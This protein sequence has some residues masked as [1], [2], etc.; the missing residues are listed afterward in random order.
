M[1]ARGPKV[2]GHGS[3]RLD[4][5]TRRPEWICLTSTVLILDEHGTLHRCRLPCMTTQSRATRG[6]PVAA[7]GARPEPWRFE[8]AAPR[9]H[10]RPCDEARLTLREAQLALASL[11]A[12]CGPGAVGG[13]Q[14]LVAVCDAHG[15]EDAATIPGHVAELARLST[16]GDFGSSARAGQGMSAGWADQE[17]HPAVDRLER[18]GPTRPR[19]F[20]RRTSRRS[21]PLPEGGRRRAVEG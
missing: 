12:L 8:S 5:A 13:G 21:A 17:P 3:K 14:A 19:G 20:N 15:L 18:R 4:R 6:C 10:G 16:H 7:A 9:W 2:C 1:G 11:Q